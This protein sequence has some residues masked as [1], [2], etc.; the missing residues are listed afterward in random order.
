MEPETTQRI[1][2][3]QFTMIGVY[4]G[5]AGISFS[6]FPFFSKYLSVT[7]QSSEAITISQLFGFKDLSSITI[8]H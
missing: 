1:S 6:T 3:G 5:L 7:S 8:S 2:H 4:F